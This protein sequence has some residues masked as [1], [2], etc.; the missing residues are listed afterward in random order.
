M[1]NKVLLIVNAKN[2]IQAKNFYND[3]LFKRFNG[4][5]YSIGVIFSI[6]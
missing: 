5:K 3:E 6:G 4:L 1:Y 2:T